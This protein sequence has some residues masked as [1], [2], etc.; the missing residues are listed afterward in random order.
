MHLALVE[1]REMWVRF[2]AHTGER[3]AVNYYF[4]CGEEGEED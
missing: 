2:L 4:W 3:E 1:L